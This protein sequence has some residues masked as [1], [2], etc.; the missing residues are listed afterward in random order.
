MHDRAQ[1]S[2]RVLQREGLRKV[3]PIR[4]PQTHHYRAGSTALRASWRRRPRLLREWRRGGRGLES[5]RRGAARL[6]G[7]GERLDHLGVY[8]VGAAATLPLGRV[9]VKREI[10]RGRIG[11]FHQ[12]V[13]Q[14]LGGDEATPALDQL[15]GHRVDKADVRVCGPLGQVVA[16]IH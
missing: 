9:R 16:A 1:V 3:L 4:Q 13:N 15:A 2:Q 6:H 10:L 14:A 8:A 12:F 7:H 5:R 11:I